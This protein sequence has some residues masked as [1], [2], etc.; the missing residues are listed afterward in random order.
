[1]SHWLTERCGLLPAPGGLA[2]VQDLLNTRKISNRGVDLLG[3][4]DLARGF[5]PG[6]LQEWAADSDRVAPTPEWVD[7]LTARDL[8]ALFDLR[9][10]VVGVTGDGPAAAPPQLPTAALELSADGR[11]SLQPTGSGRQQVAAAV[12]IEVFLAQ[13]RGDW[14]RLKICRNPV[15]GSAFFD[16]SKN[17]SGVWHDVKV[18]GNAANLRA[19]RAR[20]RLAAADTTATAA[21]S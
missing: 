11:I 14:Q 20:K 7:E 2:L 17:N 1:M 3:T 10:D 8:Q 6:L 21:Q 19:S 13:Q 15:C 9:A 5:L 18:C 16:R 12:W 4:V